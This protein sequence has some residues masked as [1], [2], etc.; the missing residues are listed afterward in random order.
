MIN[1]R[2][3]NNVLYGN[4]LNGL[5][6]QESSFDGLYNSQ[7]IEHLSLID[8]HIE[9]K[10]SY[11]NL[12]KG[13]IFRCVIPDLEVAARRYLIELDNGKKTA[14]VMLALN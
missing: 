2:F 12:R 4:I 14:S 3:P 11:K 13:G 7:K 10:N 6:V 1:I 5:P 9:L 8:F